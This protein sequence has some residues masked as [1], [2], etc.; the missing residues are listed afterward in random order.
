MDKILASLEVNE[1]ITT[2]S[3]QHSI[4]YPP[5]WLC[6]RYMVVPTL[7]SLNLLLH[8]VSICSLRGKEILG[9]A[10]YFG[11]IHAQGQRELQQTPV[12]V[13]DQAN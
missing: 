3:I 12:D 7:C 13:L 5:I 4:Y 11:E 1:N 8:T 2:E 6:L 9:R 10:I